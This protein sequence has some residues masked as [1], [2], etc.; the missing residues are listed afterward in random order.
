[1]SFHAGE[2]IT[3]ARL[4][5][6]QPATYSSN[7]SSNQALDTT[8]TDIAGASITLTTETD[9]AYFVV[10]A[11]FGFDITAATTAFASGILHLDGVEVS[12]RCRFAGEVATEYN[13]PTQLWHGAVG[14]AGSHTF[15]LRGL[16]SAGTGITTLGAYT[17]ILVTI[18]EEP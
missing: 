7:G 18:Y 11:T 15:K 3:A 4:N 2:T 9:G 16:L 13:T 17:K 6:L 5:R 10:H 8:E 12:G 1:M 14:T